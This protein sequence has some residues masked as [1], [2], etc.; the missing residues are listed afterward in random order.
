MIAAAICAAVCDATTAQELQGHGLKDETRSQKTPD[1][2]RDELYDR[3]ANAKDADE[4]EGVVSRLIL[5]YGRSGSD[6]VDLLLERSRKAMAA[7]DVHAAG[8]LLDAAIEFQPDEAAPWNARAT[9]RFLTDDYE[10]SMA[11][12][13][14]TLKREPRHLGALMGMASILAARDKKTDALAIYERIT[15]I[16]PKWTRAKEARDKLKAELAGR[17]L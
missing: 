8:Q 16:A 2:S 3:L 9:F 7:E 12:I 13:A 5:F 17:A 1:E 4:A 11:D 15:A 6:T 14:Q 10:G